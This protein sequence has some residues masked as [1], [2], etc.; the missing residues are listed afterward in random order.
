LG[1]TAEGDS[2]EPF[3]GAAFG[4]GDGVVVEEAAAARDALAGFTNST[5][6]VRRLP[7]F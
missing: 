3:G 6:K 5:R 7:M 4:S 2:D 1:D